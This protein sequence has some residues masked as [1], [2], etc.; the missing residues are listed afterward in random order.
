MNGCSTSALSPLPEPYIPANNPKLKDVLT[1]FEA[2][3]KIID[4]VVE[5]ALSEIAEKVLKEK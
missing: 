2:V 1:E 3:H 4:E 5:A